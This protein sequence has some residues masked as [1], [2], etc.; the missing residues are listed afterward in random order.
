MVLIALKWP[1]G[2]L[3]LWEGPT[4]TTTSKIKREKGKM[5]KVPGK[6][7]GLITILAAL[8][9]ILDYDVSHKYRSYSKYKIFSFFGGD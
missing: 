2:L 8:V 9:E 3:N 6:E 4:T 7:T 1:L 5:S